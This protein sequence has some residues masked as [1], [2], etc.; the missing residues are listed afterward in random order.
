MSAVTYSAGEADTRPWGE[1]RVLSAEPGCVVKRIRVTPG[2]RL[3]LQRHTHRS[4]HWIIVAGT[5]VAT[6]GEEALPLA[7]GSTV[8]IP[9]GAVHRIANTGEADLV[10]IEV[11]TGAVLSEDDIERLA[12]DFSRA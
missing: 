9:A 4:E 1:W 10:F 11:Q 5:G 3:S 8:F 7:P 2:A 12:D 6:L